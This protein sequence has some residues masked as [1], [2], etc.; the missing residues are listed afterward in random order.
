MKALSMTQPWAT[1]V[2]IGAKRIETRSWGTRYRGPLA[3]HAAKDFPAAA[4]DVCFGE[5]FGTALAAGGIADP[6]DLPR[7]VVIATCRLVDVLPIMGPIL[8]TGVKCVALDDEGIVRVWTPTEL[9][10]EPLH[11]GDIQV[12]EHEAAFGDYTPGRVAWLLS[13]VRPLPE[14]IPARG[15]RQLWEWRDHGD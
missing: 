11:V 13:D 2:A 5:P 4:F 15:N 10:G 12:N 7:G 14:P 9:G 8:P 1:L 6:T 3:I